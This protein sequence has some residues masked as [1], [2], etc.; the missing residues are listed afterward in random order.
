[1]A[2]I[3]PLGFNWPNPTAVCIDVDRVPDPETVRYRAHLE[4]ASTSV[5]HQAELVARLREL[6]AML[7]DAGQGD[8]PWMVLADPEGNEFC[9]LAPRP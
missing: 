4:L 7:V 2:N 5:E 9:L 1:M 6:G 3:E 8:V